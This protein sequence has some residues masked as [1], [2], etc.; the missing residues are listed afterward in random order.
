MHVAEAK[1]MTDKP[2]SFGA[3]VIGF[4]AMVISGY[5]AFV[6][7][8][9]LMDRTAM[10]HVSFMVFVGMWLGLTL[11]DILAHRKNWWLNIFALLTFLAFN[12]F[13]LRARHERVTFA[14]DLLH[15]V[16]RAALLTILPWSVWGFVVSQ[17]RHKVFARWER[18]DKIEV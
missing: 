8:E 11:A 6:L 17:L 18:I 14:D 10:V 12:L 13:F 7:S 2:W 16:D 4:L 1:T 15:N 9:H 3:R 5:G